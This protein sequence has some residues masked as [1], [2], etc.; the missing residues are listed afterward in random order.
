MTLLIDPQK[1]NAMFADLEDVD[2]SEI[3][4]YCHI[5]KEKH[6]KNSCK[7]PCNHNYHYNCLRCSWQKS[8]SK[9]Y[10]CPLCNQNYGTLSLVKGNKLF[11]TEKKVRKKSKTD[12]IPC[13]GTTKKGLPC[14][15]N[16]KNNGYCHIHMSKSEEKTQ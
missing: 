2:N 5:C 3:D 6:N 11:P 1:L 12:I 14:K 8:S 16:G 10:T 4:A 7:L 13:K 15:N 9:S